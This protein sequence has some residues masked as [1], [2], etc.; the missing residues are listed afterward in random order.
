MRKTV[1]AVHV[2]VGNKQ[3]LC[4]TDLQICCIMSQGRYTEFYKLLQA[5]FWPSTLQYSP[6]TQI[7]G[8]NIAI[9]LEFKKISS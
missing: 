7:F 8:Q 6:L 9:A 5:V 2:D 4:Q 3:L 1:R